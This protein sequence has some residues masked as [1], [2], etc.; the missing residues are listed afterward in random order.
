M[1]KNETIGMQNTRMKTENAALEGTNAGLIRE[2]EEANARADHF[3][4]EAQKTPE[5]AVAPVPVAD[6]VATQMAAPAPAPEAEPEVLFDPYASQNPHKFIAHPQ[7]FKLG[8]KNPSHRDN[9]RGWRG[10]V[11]VEY[12][13]FIGKKLKLYLLDPPRR[14]E[15]AVDQI[16]R[17]GDSVLA[18]LPIGMWEARQQQRTTKA[19]RMMAKNAPDVTVEQPAGGKFAAVDNSSGGKRL[20][21]G[22]MIS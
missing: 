1:A 4:A 2:L 7:G 14:M 3:E 10:W 21:G 11:K 19:N 15:H 20:G 12:N 13:D 22:S 16:V 8:W 6:A 9:H 5:P 18:Y 17:R